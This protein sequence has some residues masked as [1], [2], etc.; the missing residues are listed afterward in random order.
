MNNRQ[1]S[2]L[3]VLL[4]INYLIFSSL[5]TF[6]V[7]SYQPT[8]TPTKTP[9]PTFTPTAMNIDTP[10][11]PTP[12]ATLVLGPTSTPI[13]VPSQ[14]SAEASAEEPPQPTAQAPGGESPTATPRTERTIHVVQAGESLSIIAELYGVTYQSIQWLND[15]TN[16]SLIHSGQELLIPAPDEI[17]PSPTPGGPISPTPTPA[18]PP[19]A[20][21]APPPEAE[22]PPTE[23]PAEQ[24]QF[25]ARIDKWWPNCGLAAVG[26]SKVLDAN[27]G[28]PVNGVRI[29]IWN[30]GGYEAFSLVSGVG[31]TYG[32]GEYDIVLNNHPIEATFYLAAWDW[33]TGPDSYARVD[34]ETITLHFDTKN[35]NPEGDGHQVV[36]VNWDRHW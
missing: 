3:V 33:Q 35:C 29:R 12:T 26:K 7:G 11:P 16:P 18:P 15:I 10:P 32:P 36:I 30:D 1:W 13:E 25:T 8:P 4:L 2:I 9:L 24:H 19:E 31:L 14:P 28:E 17:I 20:P 34:S 22:P 21:P 27:S 5:I 6:V 23:P